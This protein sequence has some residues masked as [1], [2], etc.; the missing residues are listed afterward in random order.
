MKGYVY[1]GYDSSNN[2]FKIGKSKDVAR[3]EREIRNMNPTFRILCNALTENQD[4]TEKALHKKYANKRIVGEWFD[5]S[6]KDVHEI[7]G[8]SVSYINIITRRANSGNPE[9]LDCGD[10][11]DFYCDAV[12]KSQ[13]IYFCGRCDKSY[14]LDQVTRALYEES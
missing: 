8:L 3:R 4:V 6:S 10:V 12:D 2:Y 5:L 7:T 13:F 9:C 1:I 14:K 11:M